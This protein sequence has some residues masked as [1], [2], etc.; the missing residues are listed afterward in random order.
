MRIDDAI[1][2]ES[3]RD[4]MRGGAQYMEVS[5]A[6]E[7]SVVLLFCEVGL[8]RKERLRQSVINCRGTLFFQYV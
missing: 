1:E 5:A 4:E 6:R 3:A 7:R 8:W 2:E